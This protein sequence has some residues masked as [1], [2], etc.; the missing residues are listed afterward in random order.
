[1][2]CAQMEKACAYGAAR[3]AALA[4]TRELLGGE[5]RLRGDTTVPPCCVGFMEASFLG[6]WPWSGPLCRGSYG[7]FEQGS[8]GEASGADR[9][10][11]RRQCTSQR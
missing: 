10:S 6:N 8:C 1:M 7:A 11:Q 3:H 9:L 2:V 5:G 4:D